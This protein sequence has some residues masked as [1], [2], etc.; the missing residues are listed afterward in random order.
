VLEVMALL[1]DPQPSQLVRAVPGA[2]LKVPIWILGSRAVYRENFTA[3]EHLREPY[4]MLGVNVVCAE[5][6]ESD[7][8]QPARVSF[9]GSPAR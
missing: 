1:A 6:G 7:P 3:S 2:G 9:V 5:S 8:T 4:V